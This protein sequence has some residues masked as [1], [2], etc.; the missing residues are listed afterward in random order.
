MAWLEIDQ[1]TGHFKVGFRLGDRKL[2][3]SLKTSDRTEA[4]DALAVVNNTLR[5]IE[6]GWVEISPGVDIGQFL[7]SG[8]RITEAPAL[9]RTLRLSDLHNI[10]TQLG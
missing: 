2:K 5:A 10:P 9:P 6:R 4:A 1:R 8:G 3:R 7:I